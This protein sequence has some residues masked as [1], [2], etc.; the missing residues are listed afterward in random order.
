[1]R[2][3]RAY[4]ILCGIC[5]W[6]SGCAFFWK[7]SSE[8]PQITERK[9]PPEALKKKIL[10]LKFL[11]KS[12]FGGETL[13]QHSVECVREALFKHEDLAVISEEDIGGIKD[14]GLDLKTLFEK[15]RANG[16]AAIVT[17]TIENIGIREQGDE[18]GLFRTRYY[19][20]SATAQL[21]IY[22][23]ASEKELLSKMESAESVEEYT[24]FLSSEN[25]GGYKEELGKLALQKAI[26]GMLATSPNLSKQIAWTG[27]IVRV[28]SH[29]VYINSGESS[30]LKK[31]QLL[32][33]QSEGHPIFD[34]VSGVYM[35]SAPGVLKGI[36]RV[37]DF[38]GADGAV[39]VAH[40]G[41]GF[42][43]K[44]RVELYNPK[45]K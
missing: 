37:V 38:F 5:L 40:S 15:A 16:V 21:K 7:S 14:G 23:V 28:L 8:T 39:A 3:S 9:T 31:G 24:R 12:S 11:D 1:M 33:V 19:A 26:E 43:E 27:R 10:V 2:L 45:E 44:D 20:V 42:A 34:D 35:G 6:C 30:G 36:L 25:E 22:E 41:G 29:R 4:L 13:S 32:K 18:I 17:G